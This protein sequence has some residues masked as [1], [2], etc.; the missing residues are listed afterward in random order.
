MANTKETAEPKEIEKTEA[1]DPI[2]ADVMK[3][4][5]LSDP[6]MQKL[7]ELVKAAVKSDMD[8]ETQAK[9][10]AEGGLSDRHKRL[11]ASEAARVQEMDTVM[12]FQDGEKYKDDVFVGYNGKTYLIKR[13][14]T[15]PVPKG[16]KDTIANAESQARSAAKHTKGLQD[17]FDQKRDV[18]E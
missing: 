3:E 4:L 16:V 5:D 14:E 18:L 12:L 17:Q 8:K 10:E 1:P 2:E 9:A 11:Q 6:V 15:V 13:G 7:F